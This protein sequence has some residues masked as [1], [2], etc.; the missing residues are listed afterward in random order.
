[1][2]EIA[3]NLIYPRIFM[4]WADVFL[5]GNLRMKIKFLLFC[6]ACMHVLLAI[7]RTCCNEDVSRLVIE[8]ACCSLFHAVEASFLFLLVVCFG[9]GSKQVREIANNMAIY[10]PRHTIYPRGA[11]LIYPPKRG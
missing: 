6:N 1:M 2:R 3:S 11:W 5:N 9:R 10:P 8:H 4:Q 7:S